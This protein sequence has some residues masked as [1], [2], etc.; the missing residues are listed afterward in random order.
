MA[1]VD[2]LGD[3]P[4]PVLALIF[5]K[6]PFKE[7]ARTTILGKRYRSIWPCSSNIELDEKAFTLDNKRHL[8]RE[9]GRH[10]LAKGIKRTGR[11]AFVN[12]ACRFFARYHEPKIRSF[13]LHFSKPRQYVSEVNNWIKFVAKRGIQEVEVDFMDNDK[14]GWDASG[15]NRGEFP[16]DVYEMCGSLH[17][18]RLICCE[19]QPH[20]FSTFTALRTLYIERIDLNSDV[21]VVLM[22]NSR[23]LKDLS[24]V[25][26]KVTGLIKIIDKNQSLTTL[27]FRDCMSSNMGYIIETPKLNRFSYVGDLDDIEFGELPS[28]EEVE[29]NFSTGAPFQPDGDVISNDLLPGVRYAKSLTVCSYFLQVVTSGV[30]KFQLQ[31]PINGLRHLDLFSTELHQDELPGVAFLLRSYIELETLIIELGERT[32]IEDYEYPYETVLNGRA[33]WQSLHS[34]PFLCLQSHLKTV[35]IE[36]FSGEENEVEFLRFL[37]EKSEVLEE[38]TVNILKGGSL[39]EI[40]QYIVAAQRLRSFRKASPVVQIKIC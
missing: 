13:R 12:H 34:Q 14:V 1:E 28:L 22:A 11:Q 23:F 40:H 9:D 8:L 3:L 27:Y 35:K 18:L 24:L 15:F 37:L 7:G 29:F 36:G 19:F 33:F 31:E 21:L 32:E 5:G 17:T 2:R 10:S 25:E 20:R 6:L 16:H 30:N 26:M 38:I 4:D 39:P